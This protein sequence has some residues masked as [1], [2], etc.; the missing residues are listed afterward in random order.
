MAIKVKEA[1]RTPNKWDQKRKS[2]HIIIKTLNAHS[3]E[4][5]LKAARE[6]G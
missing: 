5:I 4:G 1:S 2:C 3:K 6:K